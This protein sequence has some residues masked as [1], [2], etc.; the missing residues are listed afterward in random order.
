M[1]TGTAK[2]EKRENV[3]N[4]MEELATDML[5]TMIREQRMRF[6]ADAINDIKALALNRLWPMYTTSSAG[7]TFLRRVVVEEQ[8]EKDI[9]R[10]L[11]A[12]IAKVRTNPR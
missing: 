9:E 7:R 10:E 3:I 12:A 4:L 1:T 6:S 8:I 5:D 11:Q 2:K